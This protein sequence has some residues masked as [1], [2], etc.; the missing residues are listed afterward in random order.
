MYPDR[1]VH[2]A[3]MGPIWGWQDPGGPHVCPMNIAIWVAGVLN[4]FSDIMSIL[5]EI[6]HRWMLQ[7]LFDLGLGHGLVPAVSHQAITWIKK[8][9][10]KK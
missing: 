8:K 6:A 5:C 2:G 10:K 4:V 9:K 7:A 3:N 1:K